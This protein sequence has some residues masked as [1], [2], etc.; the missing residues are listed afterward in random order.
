MYFI[1]YIYILIIIIVYLIT[2]DVLDQVLH[3][4]TNQKR[5][6]N[7]LWNE[8]YSKIYRVLKTPVENSVKQI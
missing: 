5:F 4:K 6:D 2:H 7:H 1:P 3:C 8:T